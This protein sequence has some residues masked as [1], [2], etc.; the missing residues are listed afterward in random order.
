[1]SRRQPIQ[2]L[3]ILCFCAIA[4]I[5]FSATQAASPS[6]EFEPGAGA[7][8]A[9]PLRGC[10]RFG[11][12]VED[13]NKPS[14]C[15]SGYIH[16]VPISDIQII[17]TANGYTRTAVLYEPIARQ[18]SVP[19]FGIS[20]QEAPL[21]VEPGDAVT[22]TATYTTSTGI[23]THTES[24]I[25][26]PGTMQ[27]DIVPSS[28]EPDTAWVNA[29][30]SGRHDHAMVYDAAREQTILFGGYMN[31][32]DYLRDT[33]L[34]DG[35]RWTQQQ[36][37]NPPPARRGHTMVYH[38][39]NQEVLLFGGQGEDGELLNDL[40]SWDGQRWR[41][42]TPVNTPSARTDHAMGYVNNQIVLFGGYGSLDA[43]TDTMTA[44]NDSWV[45]SGGAAG[46]IGTWTAV[47]ASTAPSSRF[48]HA[49]SYDPA[50]EN[51]VLFGGQSTRDDTSSILNDM[52]QWDGATWSQLAPAASPPTLAGHTM[53]SDPT[54]GTLLFGGQNAQGIGQDDLWIWDGNAW[55]QAVVQQSQ[56][57]AQQTMTV[58]GM[59]GPSPAELLALNA[60]PRA[61]VYQG[62]AYDAARAQLVVFG[63]AVSD[64]LS[65][66]DL[67]DTWVLDAQEI[68]QAMNWQP[69]Y[70]PPIFTRWTGVAMALEQT[71]A[72][73]STY[74]FFG[75]S[76]GS[77]LQ[78]RTFRW[79]NGEAAELSPV[80]NP[81][82]RRAHK[83]AG[84]DNQKGILLFGGISQ[85]NIYRNDTWLWQD[86]NW[87]ALALDGTQPAARAHHSLA[88][89]SQDGVWLLFG[90]L[91]ASG[92]ALN[93]VW[94]FDGATWTELKP[95]TSAD[96]TVPAPRYR[97]AFVYD[98][99]ANQMMLF[100]G[101]DGNETFYD[102]L[103]F[104][105][106]STWQ[107]VEA[108]SVA[109]EQTPNRNAF[110]RPIPRSGHGAVYNP[111]KQHLVIAGGIQENQR[112]QDT[113]IW[114]ARKG[115]QKRTDLPVLP[116]TV[117]LAMELD[118]AADD[119]KLVAFGE[120]NGGNALGEGIFIHEVISETLDTFPI[121]MINLINPKDAYLNEEVYAQAYGVDPDS[122]RAVQAYR[123]IHGEHILSTSP[124]FTLDLDDPAYPM[125][126]G[127][128]K[129]VLQVQD[130]EGNWSQGI[131]QSLFVREAESG[132]LPTADASETWTLLLYLSADDANPETGLA[133]ILGDS[134]LLAELQNAGVA[135]KVNVAVLYDGLAMDDS[136]RYTL[137]PDG[138]WAVDNQ[139]LASELDMSERTTLQEFVEWGR[140]T[141]TSTYY[142]LHIVGASNGINGLGIDMNIPQTH[143]L[144][145]I[146]QEEDPEQT[147]CSDVSSVNPN[148]LT[149]L[150]LREALRAATGEGT[151]KLDLLH[152]D[153]SSFGLF[154]NTAIADDVA[155]FV[156][157]SPSPIIGL[158]DYTTYRT[159]ASQSD[160]PQAYGQQLVAHYANVASANNQPYTISLFD[161][162]H[163][164]AL[165]TSVN[166]LGTTLVAYVD[167][168][169]PTRTHLKEVRRN[170]HHYESGGDAPNTVDN[171]DEYVDLGDF[172]RILIAD[173]EVDNSTVTSAATQVQTALSDFVDV[174]QASD[175]ASTGIGI[176]Y[177]PN[178]DD[179]D[180]AYYT[181][182]ENCR[183]HITAESGWVTFIQDIGYPPIGV[184]PAPLMDPTAL[185]AP[186]RLGDA[187][188]TL[189]AQTNFVYLPVVTK[190]I[191]AQK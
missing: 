43:E 44:L 27:L 57:V 5:Q 72:D 47:D 106:D 100:G 11:T 138:T 12:P 159:L 128:Q 160:S 24:F 37:L 120:L 137:L 113:W 140:E 144:R 40:W 188:P 14:C 63:G 181:Y 125:P 135:E 172:V 86:E 78:N 149:P 136:M 102:D 150:E 53:V 9:L 30:L 48:S 152:F 66:A 59:A 19:E 29:H 6:Q 20:L 141:F 85:N 88:Y 7:I 168:H 185:L 105:K 104:F 17:A 3:K 132:A 56:A 52:W 121:G 41:K 25:A 175:E 35:T 119:E 112:L 54:V 87:T 36:T 190:G 157:A 16:T 166:D 182:I 33:W 165:N 179:V 147:F 34:W 153:G 116:P 73:D 8:P 65:T 142:A 84:T 89:S 145:T 156:V 23:F 110:H 111:D 180:S 94:Q 60:T 51:L 83:L 186:L 122:T 80:D 32:G 151:H 67:A 155:N 91:D 45:W 97:T 76:A 108:S 118:P 81:P 129:L 167:G 69:L 191:A 82:A 13:Y 109:E 49:I 146:A 169:N 143:A 21:N 189:P 46:D 130:N 124:S 163:F 164:D 42:L 79:R 115:W 131:E 107:L 75:G 162:A 2:L 92:N 71:T 170:A 177:P 98:A 127:E 31:R 1:M 114:T 38:E 133:T 15:V 28:M 64:P 58:S 22:L 187:N 134:G 158:F 178:I 77:I 117:I 171:N 184:T 70:S 10:Y 183:F 123:W 139:G 95:N 55:T 103:W 126:V 93:D 18:N 161:M 148:I 62:M 4:L 96:S 99:V 154:E 61:R 39:A 173:N 50:L 26:R 68:T 101:E 174:Y 90:G 176:Y 74:L